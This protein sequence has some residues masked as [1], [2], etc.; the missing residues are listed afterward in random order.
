MYVFT[1]RQQ[2]EL[3]IRHHLKDNYQY[4]EGSRTHASQ[5]MYGIVIQEHNDLFKLWFQNKSPSSTEGFDSFEANVLVKAT[6]ENK[7]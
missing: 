2:R 6:G 4:I 3:C 5:H 7:G 1:E